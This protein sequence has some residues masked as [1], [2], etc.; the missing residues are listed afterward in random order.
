MDL[1]K[2]L[3]KSK[4]NPENMR[5]LKELALRCQ[6]Y[7]IAAKIRDLEIEEEPKED[8]YLLL[9]VTEK[10]GQFH[11]KIDSKGFDEYQLIG[12]LEVE[13]QKINDIVHSQ[14]NKNDT[15]NT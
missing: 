10:D 14:F 1:N 13:K 7:E 8:R 4:D 12:I 11:V 6:E 3:E 5:R 2:L 15:Q 9:H